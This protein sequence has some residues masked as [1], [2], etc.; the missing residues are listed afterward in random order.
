[1]AEP[2]SVEA[3]RNPYPGL[4][5]FRTDEERL[6]FGRE[7]QIDR[8]IDKLGANRFLAVVGGSGSGKSS[9]VNCGLRPAL[10][11]GNLASAGAAWRMAQF[12]P[13][14]DPIGALAG[15]LAKPGVLFEK[16]MTGGL[17]AEA[18]IEATL[19]LGSLGLVDM[20]D[21]MRL[22][23][24]TQMLV[25]VDQFEELFRFRSLARDVAKDA[26]GPA[27]D[28]IAFVR[29]LLEARAQTDVPIH[30]VLTM[31]SDFLGDCSQFHGLPEAINEG[32]YLVPRLTRE[33]IRAAIIGPAAVADATVSPVLLTRLLNDVGD[34]PDQLSILQHALNRTWS[35]WERSGEN[36]PL[37]LANYE[38]IGTM[39]HALDKHA[40]RA[41]AELTTA[42]Q[43][44]IC[45][46]LFK[47]LTDKATDPRGIRRPTRLGTLCVL[48]D[49]TP[50]EVTQVIDVFRKPSRSFLMPPAGDT[51]EAETVIDISHESLMRVWERLKTWADDEAEAAHIY[52]RLAE[53]A[54]LHGEGKAGLWRGPDLQRAL[55]WRATN[56]PK[57]WAE[58][59]YPGF[60]TAIE[61]LKDSEDDRDKEVAE[62]KRRQTEEA[63]RTRVE[64][65][66]TKALFEEQQKR[67][68]AEQEKVKEREKRLLEQRKAAGKLRQW[69][70]IAAALCVI[71]GILS[72]VAFSFYISARKASVK[73]QRL[74][75]VSNMNLAQQAFQAAQ[76]GQVVNLLDNYRPNP[77][78]PEVN[79][80]R[81]FLWY[82]LWRSSHNE[83]GTLN[84]HTA[85][86]N[87][88]A[89]SPDGKTLA[90]ASDDKTVKLWDA[91][92]HRELA[93]LTGH[94]D[95]VRAVA[96]SPDGKT[97]ASGGDD[98]LV[99]LWDVATRRE[100][101]TFTK[102]SGAVYTLAFSPDGKML[103]ASD[104]QKVRLW[105]LVSHRELAPL[106]GQHTKSIRA[107]AFSPDGETIASGGLDTHVIL[108]SATTQQKLRDFLLSRY[109]YSLSFSPDG[110]QLAAGESDRTVSLWDAGP[111]EFRDLKQLHLSDVYSVTFSPDGKYLASASADGTIKLWDPAE[112]KIL[113][114]LSG[115]LAFVRAVAFSSDGR[116]ASASDDKTVKFWNRATRRGVNELSENRNV[117][118]VSFSPD[119]KTLA[120]ASQASE[121]DIKA[122]KDNF[123]KLWDV[124]TRK[125]WATLST[126]VGY[127]RRVTFSPD[128]KLLAAGLS[129]GTV[130]EWDTATR[131]ELASFPAHNGNVNSVAFSPDSKTLAS[132]GDDGLVK[133]WQ[134]GAGKE[135]P[136]EA[137][138]SDKA[139]YSLTFSPDGKTVASAGF[140]GTVK[141]WNAATHQ[142]I[143]SLTK[144]SQGILSVAF[145]PNGK[146]LA[147]GS[148]DSEV[149]LWNAATWKEIVTLNGHSQGVL[150]LAFSPNGETLASGSYDHRAKLWDVKTGQELATIAQDSKSIYSV[151]FSLDGKILATAGFD[152]KK[153]V[154]LWFAA[155]NEEILRQ[156][157]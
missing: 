95:P 143:T 155:T 26:Y 93:T 65:E 60:E 43:R 126:G 109:V 122:G 11:R 44:Q 45:E 14:N 99:K 146:I 1:M 39:T 145:S 64:L 96:F 111:N 66:S 7:H 24:S 144:Q 23:P 90:S 16:P 97:V 116:I 108:W 49:A 125:D 54:V 56:Q 113:V 80:L 8:M 58:R 157:Q 28:A 140:D 114:T 112:R 152:Q 105:D 18:L 106:T 75:Y 67:A 135:L 63:E 137:K 85:P 59:Y 83:E 150:S 10:H 55:K 40:E 34:N 61:F 87:A 103:A 30:V 57:D 86:V 98:G 118:S 38:A 46:K 62:A 88:I 131:K 12:R 149:K 19:R 104:D 25:V 76:F 68:D 29:L 81:S 110:K 107:V 35:Q 117:Y 37:D 21:Q 27:E 33:E 115:H 123:V 2:T 74:R 15:G 136:E 141:I 36:E 92:S 91:G 78:A 31:R 32:Q 5:P 77:D 6:F 124:D 41:Y 147:S 53:T 71:A 42:P 132:A 130:K 153:E 102:A 22:P 142:L 52:C 138:H 47:A 84:G 3:V 100:L 94:T 148:F 13:G 79:D 119:G 89:F 9:L 4:R 139:V 17:S 120:S 69:F 101:A 51:L 70:V 151:A 82:Y 133:F 154:K 20:V 48:A 156:S 129:D 127:P 128:G 72:V 50:A 134:A 121:D 73:T